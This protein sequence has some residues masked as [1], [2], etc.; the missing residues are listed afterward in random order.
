MGVDAQ[1]TQAAAA[2]AVAAAAAAAT[3]TSSDA[4][5]SIVSPEAAVAAAAPTPAAAAPGAKTTATAGGHS[6][7]AESTAAPEKSA[8][9]ATARTTTAPTDKAANAQT[10]SRSAAAERLR[11][12]L[13][14]WKMRLVSAFFALT[15]LLLLLF[16]LSFVL[17]QLNP[18]QYHQPQSTLLS[19]SAMLLLLQ[20]QQKQQQRQQQKQQKQ[21]KEKQHQQQPRGVEENL[22]SEQ[23]CPLSPPPEQ[24]LLQQEE[25]VSTCPSLNVCSSRA[26]LLLKQLSNKKQ[27]VQQASVDAQYSA[28]P[29]TEAGEATGTSHPS[30]A[31]A[32]PPATAAAVAA[33]DAFEGCSMLRVSFGTQRKKRETVYPKLQQKQQLEQQQ[34]KEEDHLG[35]EHKHLLHL[36]K[37]QVQQHQQEHERQQQQQAGELLGYWHRM[38]SV[39]A[40]ATPPTFI[41]DKHFI[42]Q[43]QNE[44][45]W[46]VT[47]SSKEG[48]VVAYATAAATRSSSSSRQHTLTWWVKKPLQQKQQQ[49]W[50]WVRSLVC[51]CVATDFVS[52][53][54]SPPTS[55]VSSSRD[56]LFGLEAAISVACF[57][58]DA[59]AFFFAADN[60]N[61]HPSCFQ[62]LLQPSGSQLLLLERL[63]EASQA[64]LQDLQQQPILQ[65]PQQQQQHQGQQQH[66]ESQGDGE[67]QSDEEKEESEQEKEREEGG[68]IDAA[69]QQQQEFCPRLRVWGGLGAGAASGCTGNFVF[70]SKLFDDDRLLF[71]SFSLDG[72]KMF[73]ILEKDKIVCGAETA[74]P[75]ALGIHTQ[76]SGNTSNSSTISSFDVGRGEAPFSA[77]F[78]SCR[79]QHQQQQQQ[80]ELSRQNQRQKQQA[81]HS[82]LQ[83]LL[84]SNTVQLEGFWLREDG[85]YTHAKM[86]LEDNLCSALSVVGSPFAVLNGLWRQ[87][88]T[89]NRRPVFIKRV[90]RITLAAAAPAALV[91]PA[92]AEDAATGLGAAT[93]TAAIAHTGAAAT[94]LEGLG[95]ATKG[96]S[97]A[98]VTEGMLLLYYDTA[99]FWAVSV[100]KGGEDLLRCAGSSGRAYSKANQEGREGGISIHGEEKERKRH[101]MAQGATAASEEAGKPTEAKNP[102]NART[103]KAQGT[104]EEEGE[105]IKTD[106]ETKTK[107]GS[108]YHEE[109]SIT[110][111]KKRSMRREE[112][113]E[114]DGYV[115]SNKKEK[116]VVFM[117]EAERSS[118]Y[119]PKLI[120]VSFADS[121]SPPSGPWLF[122]YSQGNNNKNLQNEGRTRVKLTTQEA[123]A[124]ATAAATA[125]K[126]ANTYQHSVIYN[127]SVGCTHS[128]KR[129]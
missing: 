126:A 1:N 117:R 129:L 10:G 16:V 79:Q 60:Q 52:L 101:R 33:A 71:S 109:Q 7:A 98:A 23:Q 35:Q 61:I 82:L 94:G 20:K 69:Q 21:Q 89:H 36:H 80:E 100:C 54:A 14:C 88:G 97:S 49:Q 116:G 38:H 81:N 2:A 65:P 86:G 123:A 111:N 102:K 105:I 104:Q 34:H 9:A 68:E 50:D 74:V 66:P 73:L 57:G 99:G 40:A 18:V 113:N 106:K 29:A 114:G 120:A 128:R 59:S 124:K 3:T 72:R 30:V 64:L 125:A 67:K 84:M 43:Q 37:Q 46:T 90:S 76:D 108:V 75:A 15:L 118:V 110:T 119:T 62:L 45:F 26:N 122:F 39:Y 53:P 87:Q 31:P 121:P 107:E 17:R 8:A 48:S 51:E 27:Q 11:L 58:A 55:A 24:L 103:N 56:T 95:A 44:H 12:L 77:E 28:S 22:R 93:A 19:S 13:S 32:A 85:S 70:I 92:G 42:L 127:L 47:S 83:L 96:T 25:G 4:A 91:V 41:S 6:S 5:D 112:P 78:S 63:L 115:H